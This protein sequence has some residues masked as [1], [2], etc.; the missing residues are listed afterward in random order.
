MARSKELFRRPDSPVY[1][2]RVRDPA[3]GKLVKK[4][5]G[6]TT[7]REA[8]EWKR[9]YA[10]HAKVTSRPH[11]LGELCDDFLRNRATR[12]LSVYTIRFYQRLTGSLLA[13]LGQDRIAATINA[14]TVDRFIVQ[15]Q[16]DGVS[17]HTITKELYCLR[18]VLRVAKR[19]EKWNGDTD[20]IFPDA[21]AFRSSYDRS[22]AARRALT[23]ENLA[24][25]VGVMPSHHFAALAY[26]IATGAEWSALCRARREDVQ[27]G[28]VHVRGTKN[29]NRNRQVP[30]VLPEQAWLLGYALEHG[31]TGERLF[32]MSASGFRRALSQAAEHAGVHHFSPHNARHTLAV[33]LRTAGVDSATTGAV[34]GHSSGLMVERTYAH[35]SKAE[36]LAAS[37]RAQ[38]GRQLGAIR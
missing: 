22:K 20:K 18:V 16:R 6:C 5:T 11:T 29:S 8:V 30:I 33:W 17:N 31:S 10:A 26:A 19:L 32:P 27:N 23:R 36:D 3:T 21:G 7:E 25:L 35:L 34:L 2:C 1:Y 28:F 15:R 37:L 38:L 9:N 24:D 14:D 12:S 4:S 13:T